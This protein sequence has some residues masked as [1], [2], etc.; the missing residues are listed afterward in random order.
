M[1]M[2]KRLHP[3]PELDALVQQLNSTARAGDG[4]DG[5]T[6]GETPADSPEREPGGAVCFR[7]P[8]P[9]DEGQVWLNHL[10]GEARR[11]HASDLAFVAGAAPK[12]RVDGRLDSLGERTLTRDAAGLLSAAIVPPGRRA[13]IQ[14]SG[15]IDF[16]FSRPGLGRFRCNTHRERGSWSAAIRLFP[17]ERPELKQLNLPA[18]IERLAD[19]EHGLV[20]VTGPTGC[21][22]STTLAAI[23]RRILSRRRVHLITIEDPVEYEHPHGDSV[24]EH[25]EI[26][27]DANSFA[28]ALRSAM[29]QDPDVV[30]IGEMRDLESISIAITAAETGHL[31]LSTLHT[32]DGPQTIHR[33]LDSYPPSQIDTVRTQL[34]ISLAGIISQQL[35]PRADGQGRV[36]AVEIMMATLAVRNLIRQGKIQLLRSQL[37]LERQFGM[38]ALDRSLARLASAGTVDLDEARFR[39]RSP[40]EFDLALNRPQG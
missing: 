18:G 31:V 27:R 30:L 4:S 9:T 8:E 20:L 1:A 14:Q 23:V 26:G 40:E 33:I 11:L 7:L 12:V 5:E 19:C 6:G 13:E 21:G 32:G 3:D 16:S 10:L 25:I 29:R 35:L 15:A 37:T 34:S 22:K 38:L 24:V 2:A 17:D 39:A 28:Q 36:P